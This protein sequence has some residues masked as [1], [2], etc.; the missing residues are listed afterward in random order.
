MQSVEALKGASTRSQLFESLKVY[1]SNKN[2]LQPIIGLGSIIECVKAAGTHNREVL[3][4]C[5]VCVCRLS[6]ADMRNHIMGSLHRYNYIKAW[7]PHL[8]SEWEEKC[9]LS[10]LAWPLMEMA[11]TLEGKE[12]HGEV[13]WLEVDDAVYQK[14]ATHSEKDAV[15]LITILRDGQVQGEPESRS[16]T[17][18]VQL[19]H[20][21]VRSQR[22]VLLPQTS[23]ETNQTVA[24]IE[25]EGSLK[26]TSSPEPSE[27]SE[28]GDSF[29][30]GYTGTKPLIGLIRVVECRSEDGHTCCFLC[31][32]CRIR[33][34]EKN[35]IDHLTRSSH[36]VNY[37]MEIHPEQVEVMMADIND[38]YQLLQSLA[39][40][41][42][43]EEGRGELKVVNAPES[44]C[45]LLTG[46][47]Y[48][49]CVKMLCNGW[50]HTNTQKQKIAVRGTSLNKTSNQCMPEKCAVVPSKSAKKR[51]MR[52]VTNPVFN[53]S[54]PLNEGSMLLER[55]SFSRDSLPVSTAYSTPSDSDLVPSPESQSQGCELDYDT[56]SITVDDAEHTSQLQQDLYSGDGD[57]GQYMEPERNVTPYQEVDGYLND[58]EYF[59]QSEDTTGANYQRVS[60]ENNYN[61]QQ[62]SQERSRFYKEWQN[63][64][65]QT[66]HE[67][68][69]PAASYTQDWSSYNSSYGRD[70]GCTE[71]WYNSSSQSKVGTGVSR[72]G[73]NGMSSDAAQHYYQQQPQ[74]QYMAQDHTS[75]QTGGVGQ[76][77]LSSELA[78]Y[79][80]ADRIN[81]HPYLGDP[82][83]HNG[84]IALE[85]RMQFLEFEQRRLQTYM[86]FTFGH[87]Q[88]ASQS[89]MTQPT[90][91]QAFH[92]G[93][94]MMSY[95]NYNNEP[96]NPDQPFPHPVSG[97]GGGEVGSGG[98]GMSQ[99]NA[100]I[101]PGQALYYGANTDLN[102]R[103]AGWSD[104]MI[105][106]SSD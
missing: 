46:K 103:A 54:L 39:E 64:G 105:S 35:I 59:N 34:N 70:A 74:N 24:F 83:A 86:E 45:S 11:K 49:W 87:F 58:D 88:T 36:L 51:K 62:G 78:A 89:Y 84:S 17:T 20:S 16:E 106:G 101:P 104:L 38:N 28:N 21:P 94:G 26:N 102:F 14:M 40:K 2:R 68:L 53:V 100:F 65:P 95:P 6:K 97:W 22:I 79:S 4:L 77:G 80:G 33:S 9:D 50:T 56:G 3:Y 25:S 32:C 1:L 55:S 41:V 67:W 5:E 99:S 72:E 92:V 52:E 15:T 48:H 29:L 69:S 27:P 61:G 10:K 42:E 43:Q 44:L 18:S 66:Q 91:H 31:H 93:H 85:P 71:Q 82:R 76:H 73:Q 12:G 19:E 63:D 37:L 81:T 7:H 60:G 96:T 13:Q 75:L 23:A 57:A 90:A 30:D 98:G 8:V 47:S